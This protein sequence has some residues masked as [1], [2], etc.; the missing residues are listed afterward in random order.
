MSEQSSGPIDAPAAAP[1]AA[2]ETDNTDAELAA[3]ESEES[4]EEASSQSKESPEASKAAPKAAD[5]AAK[6]VGAKKVDSDT[7]KIKVDGEELELSRDEMIKYAQQGRAGQKRMAE[8]AQIK[9]EA[10]DLVEMLR[11]D[12]EAILSDPAILGSR[13]EVI[14]FA[15]RILANQM[16][17]EMKSPEVREKEAAQK[18]LED[19][20]KK[21]KDQ[22]EANSKAEYDRLVAQEEEKLQNEINEAIDSS[23]LPASPFVLKRI[24]DVL[25]MAAENNKNIS[26]KQAMNIVKKE[27]QK[28]IS[29]YIKL[30]PDEALEE[31][32]GGERI[33]S[34]RKKQL[35]K[36]KAQAEQTKTPSVN[37]QLK[38]VQRQELSE[39]PAAEKR[40]SMKDFLRGR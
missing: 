4:T 40:V 21:I 6:D 33:K 26:P 17:E 37:S 20:R 12:P 32:M 30:S 13:D 19:L 27:M 18:E 11:S 36:V 35:S 23:G 3:L 1:E 31:L 16:E 7:Y 28:D 2:L 14:K 39:K 25:I 24:S 5:K 29:E 34:L 10:I 22:E 9:K 15:Q 38:P 8:A